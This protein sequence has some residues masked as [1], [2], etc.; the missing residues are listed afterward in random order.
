M[1][2]LSWVVAGSGEV[3]TTV[4]GTACTVKTLEAEPILPAASVDSTTRVWT[5]LA[6]GPKCSPLVFVD[7]YAIHFDRDGALAGE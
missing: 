7:E 4:G 5:P 1:G 2:V 6:R 3:M